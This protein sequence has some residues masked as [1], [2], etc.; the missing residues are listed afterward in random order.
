MFRRIKHYFLNICVL[1]P[2]KRD[3]YKPNGKFNAN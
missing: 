2:Q 1:G 3:K